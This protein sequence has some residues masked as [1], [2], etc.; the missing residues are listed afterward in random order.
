MWNNLKTRLAI[1]FI[2]LAVIPLIVVG[3]VLIQQSIT[4]QM[5]Q[6]FQLEHQIVKR[7]SDNVATLIE[8]REV[9]LRLL[10]E[11]RSI[12]TL[13]SAQQKR[14][15]LGL[16][17]NNYNDATLIAPDGREIIHVSRFTITKN[18]ADNDWSNNTSFD[19]PKLTQ[20]TFYSSVQFHPETN[21]P[22][23]MLAVPI[24]NLRDNKFEGVLIG[25]VRFKSVWDL[26]NDIQT[27][28]GRTVYIVDVDSR[29]I[30]HPNSTI[31][32]QGT[33]FTPPHQNGFHS[34]LDGK[35]VIMG[36][37]DIQLGDQIFTIVVENNI[38]QSLSL[39]IATLYTTLTVVIVALIVAVGLSVFASHRIVRPIDAAESA[40]Q[41]KSVF[42]ANMSHELRTP[43]NA[44]LGF[45]QLMQRSTDLS[46]EN[47]D[48]LN[49]IIRSGE[50]LLALIND[51][52]EMSKLEA[53]RT[54]IYQSSF[55]LPSLL[56]DL[57]SMLYLQAANKR[58]EFQV[59]YSDDIPQYI[60]TDKQ[61]LRQILI[62]LLTNAI[63]FTVSGQVAIQVTTLAMSNLSQTPYLLRFEVT[64]TGRGIDSSEL[65]MLFEPFMQAKEG[66]RAEEGSGLGLAISQQF[67]ELLG[68]KIQVHSEVGVGSRFWFDIPI[69]LGKKTDVEIHNKTAQ[70]II[71]LAPG[72]P[73]YRLLIVDDKW[74]N[75]NLLLKLLEPFGFELRE[76]NNGI[77]AMTEW[78]TWQPDL[79]WMDIRMPIMDGYE[80][81]KKI[82][83]AEKEKATVIIALSAFEEKRTA[84]LAA[85]CD[86][87]INK[88]YKETQIFEAMAKHLGVCYLYKD[89]ADVEAEVLTIGEDILTPARLRK[90]PDSW[91]MKLANAVKSLNL[92][93][94]ETII[95][96]ISTQ[97][98]PL[99]QQLSKLVN[100]FR[101]DVLQ[102]LF[103]NLD[104][105][106]GEA[107]LTPN[108]LQK[109]PLEWQITLHQAVQTVDIEQAETVIDQ[110]QTQDIVLAEAL[111]NLVV[112]FRF[113]V[114]QKLF[115]DIGL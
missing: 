54:T 113:D 85:G 55:D 33:R 107:I 70:S 15:L 82:R 89:E 74:E 112:E 72:Q 53:G 19:M 75:R 34:G 58:V 115:E 44:V 101:F 17:K 114:L 56:K 106:A 25:S 37:E 50:H 13:D 77:E 65:D 22:F 87:F 103:D 83:D 88:P 97:D 6:S 26:L 38:S 76:A 66:K 84:V 96:E 81:I 40:N 21:D 30:A 67:V 93:T 5:N 51:V 94:S 7:I 16:L 69:K 48:N 60:Y 78:E 45:S 42:L 1:I 110:I 79:I 2:A 20:K 57:H 104:T 109:L 92:E 23:I 18:N 49:T 46:E 102:E 73:T 32:L 80:A 108:R 111:S 3:G 47:R 99:A 62:N 27:D 43:L 105:P 95:Q 28:S 61:K 24:I 12:H 52:L 71:G 90:L 14:L 35:Q 63:K 59:D 4:V 68:G 91:R 39:T 29:V 11:V 36:I 9:E 31:I 98:K 41:A 10:T 64:D 100:E 86:D 8:Q